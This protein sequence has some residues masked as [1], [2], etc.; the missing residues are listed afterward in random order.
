MDRGNGWLEACRVSEA[1]SRACHV[2][3]CAVFVSYRER[4]NV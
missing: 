1:I 3:Y 4:G 2:A